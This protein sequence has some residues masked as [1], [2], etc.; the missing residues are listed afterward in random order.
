MPLATGLFRDGAPQSPH[1]RDADSLIGED[2]SQTKPA[3]RDGVAESQ[4][5]HNRLSSRSLA[6][7][8]YTPSPRSAQTAGAP[9]RSSRTRKRLP[10][11]S[12]ERAMEGK[13]TEGK[14]I[15]EGGM[16]EGKPMPEGAVM[17]AKP[18]AGV[19]VGESVAA[20]CQGRAS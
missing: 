5:G 7:P 9:S 19:T 10:V 15:P 12:E 13:S 6:Y 2:A 1:G 17:E 11:P 20:E 8:S 4:L 3:L 16:R 14:S 18:T